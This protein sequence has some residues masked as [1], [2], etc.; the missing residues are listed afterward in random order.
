MSGHTWPNKDPNEYLDFDVDWAGS[1]V[2]P[3]RT[4][5]DPL[6]SS[7]WFISKNDDGVLIMESDSY[8]PTST[9][10]WLSGGTLGRRYSITNRISTAGGR[11]MDITGFLTVR[12][13]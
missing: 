13:K 5:N 11:I 2:A 7:Q 12:E 4:Y 10:L 6:T 9:K 3:G 8:S 1:A